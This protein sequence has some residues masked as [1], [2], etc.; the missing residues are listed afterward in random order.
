AFK[1]LIGILPPGWTWQI[2]SPVRIP[3][4]DEP[5]P[6]LAILRGS[7]EDFEARTPEAVNVGLGIEVSESTLD[8]DR[9]EKLLAY[10]KG[11]IPVYWIVNL[12]DRQIEV[13][14]NPGPA[15]YAS[16]VDFRP[17]QEVPVVIGGI[18]VGRIHVDAILPRQ[19][20]S[21]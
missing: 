19:Q 8:R 1:A 21:S 10:A 4:F 13:Y 20:A 3:D 9:G 5:A 6:D 18:E 11:G 15:G 14:T 2:E 16:R 7:D 17:G 12:V